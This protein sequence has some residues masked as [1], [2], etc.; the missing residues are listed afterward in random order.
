MTVIYMDAAM[1]MLDAPSAIQHNDAAH[2]CP[3]AQPGAVIDTP[4]NPVIYDA[5]ANP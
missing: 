4:K 3:G 5:G 1:R 2:W